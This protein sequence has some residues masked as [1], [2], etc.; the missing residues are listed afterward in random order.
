[1]T[2]NIRTVFKTG[3]QIF[4]KLR[5]IFRKN[6]SSSSSFIWSMISYSRNKLFLSFVSRHNIRCENVTVGAYK[7]Y[8]TSCC[9]LENGPFTYDCVR[10]LSL[11]SKKVPAGIVQHS[12]FFVD[13]YEYSHLGKFYFV[14]IKVTYVIPKAGSSNMAF[15]IDIHKGEIMQPWYT[16]KCRIGW[17]KF[18]WMYLKW[19][20]MS[21]YTVIARGKLHFSHTR[22]NLLFRKHKNLSTRS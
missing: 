19:Y 7:Q 22:Q 13:S 1:M 14:Y 11:Y 3:E 16:K 18:H 4:S 17:W 6:R 9:L 2:K 5:N 21:W 20:R 15:R 12:D 10:L 8:L